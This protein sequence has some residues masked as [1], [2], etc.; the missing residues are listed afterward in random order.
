MGMPAFVT[1]VSGLCRCLCPRPLPSSSIATS[2]RFFPTTATHATGRITS[3]RKSKL[4][5]D[6]EAG[7]KADLGGHFAI[8]PGNAA[9]SELIRRVTADDQARRMPPP[10]PAPPS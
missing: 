5:L 4:R 3:K 7:A 9:K 8:V 1:A 6:T 10:I 2:G